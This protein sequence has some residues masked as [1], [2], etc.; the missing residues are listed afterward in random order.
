[1]KK[2]PKKVRALTL[3]INSRLFPMLAAKGIHSIYA[4]ANSIDENAGSLSKIKRGISDWTIEQLEKIR[5][6]HA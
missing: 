4:L 6:I 2:K 5:T 1:M 3:K